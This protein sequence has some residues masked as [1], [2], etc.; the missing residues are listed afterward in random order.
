MS[1]KIICRFGW[2]YN[3]KLGEDICSCEKGEGDVRCN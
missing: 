1:N 2:N 3:E